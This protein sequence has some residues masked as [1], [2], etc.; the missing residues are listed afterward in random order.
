MSH[1]LQVLVL[2]EYRL[3]TVFTIFDVEYYLIKYLGIH[4]GG[5][6]LLHNS[7]PFRVVNC[8]LFPKI[9][10]RNAGNSGLFKFKHFVLKALRACGW[11]QILKELG[12]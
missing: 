8:F 4:G 3:E 5:W 6:V 1:S 10:W 2:S 7:T 9:A 11:I 12:F